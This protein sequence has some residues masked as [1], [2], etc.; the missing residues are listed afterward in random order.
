MT[1]VYIW[2]ILG[3]TVFGNT[4]HYGIWKTILNNYTS[5]H[6]KLSENYK[7]MSYVAI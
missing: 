2:S 6:K 3:L 7:K 1:S 5:A 4:R